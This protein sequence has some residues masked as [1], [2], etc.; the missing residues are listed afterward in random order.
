MTDLLEGCRAKI[1]RAKEHYYALYGEY[2]A[3]F[4]RNPFGFANYTNPAA[5]EQVYLARISRHPPTAGGAVHD[6]AAKLPNA[7]AG[8]RHAAVVLDVLARGIDRAARHAA[9]GYRD[10]YPLFPVLGGDR[11]A[12]AVGPAPRPRLRD[13]GDPEAPPV[14][15]PDS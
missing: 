12:L 10:R 6:A 14:E 7:L 5:G 4:E 15:P 2:G 8:D 3:F 9:G 1:E 11:A 13:L